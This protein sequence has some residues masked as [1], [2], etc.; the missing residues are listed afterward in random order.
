[1][2]IRHLEYFVAAAEAPGA[3]R[4]AK[5]LKV[6]PSAVFDAVR[7]V[8]TEFRIEAFAPTGDEGVL[9]PAG[10]RLLQHARNTLTVL[11][12][13]RTDI[14]E[15]RRRL[16][17]ALTVVTTASTGSLDLAGALTEFHRHHPD[18]AIRL[19]A[20]DGVAA[21]PLARIGDGT[22]DLAVLALHD[23]HPPRDSLSREMTVEQVGWIQ[24]ALAC[25]RQ[26]PLAEGQ[27]SFA[28][29]TPRT[30]VDFPARWANR[31][32]TDGL[33]AEQGAV[34]DVGVEVADFASAAALVASGI[35]IGFLPIE[36]IDD[37]PA[38]TRI[39]L[40]PA[41]DP[42]PVCLVT[43]RHEDLSDAALALT[44]HLISFAHQSAE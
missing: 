12:R 40:S 26:D 1:M 38:L 4:A 28:D 14:G 33:F 27:Y 30:F 6:S 10:Q 22:A 5:R 24:T 2:E 44:R 42:V 20:A 8:E 32:H 18:L 9:T 19:S 21:E 36:L 43:R 15:M 11:A 25:T 31:A 35:G 17:G 29:L 34:R 7:R 16:A 41:P 23:Q 3:V 39:A 37:H 13:A